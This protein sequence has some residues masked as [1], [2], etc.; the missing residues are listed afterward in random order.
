V[1]AEMLYQ[2]LLVTGNT[3]HNAPA[4]VWVMIAGSLAATINIP[5]PANSL[6]FTFDVSE[7]FSGS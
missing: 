4:G 1:I 5:L 6:Q 3:R 2:V 7:L